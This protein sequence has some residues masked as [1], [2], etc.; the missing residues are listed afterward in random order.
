[1]HITTH[2]QQWVLIDQAEDVDTYIQV[3]KIPS[4]PQNE[5]HFIALFSKKEAKKRTKE[6]MYG[7]NIIPAYE[8]KT[9]C[10]ND[11][12]DHF[13][14]RTYNVIGTDDKPLLESF[15]GFLTYDTIYGGRVYYFSN[16]A[17]LL[18][19]YGSYSCFY[20]SQTQYQNEN[21]EWIK[22]NEDE[23][24]TYFIRVD[25]P[26]EDSLA[27]YKIDFKPA[28]SK[29]WQKYYSF[30]EP[31]VSRVY[32]YKLYNNGQKISCLAESWIGKKSAVSTVWLYP[33]VEPRE[34]T[35][36][37]TRIYMDWTLLLFMEGKDAVVEKSNSLFGKNTKK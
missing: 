30:N 19:N 37:I 15:H 18:K 27:M 21:A 25:L 32:V 35:E 20:A 7:S 8:D 24:A 29:Q 6:N 3:D 22:F 33:W 34:V 31:P 23:Y 4:S 1:M 12:F 5:T 28:V 10:F 14:T 16:W 9:Y 36:D 11:A 17:C 2:A 26:T 13:A